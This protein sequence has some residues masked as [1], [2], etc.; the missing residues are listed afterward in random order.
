MRAPT[1]R[2]ADLVNSNAADS[3]SWLLLK[4]MDGIGRILKDDEPDMEEIR[5]IAQWAQ[6]YAAGI[7]EAQVTYSLPASSDS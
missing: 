1:Q 2:A 7:L 4:S 5:F 6:K 3:A